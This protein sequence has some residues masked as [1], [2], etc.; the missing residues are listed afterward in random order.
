MSSRSADCPPSLL[1]CTFMAM[2]HQVCIIT[3][4]RDP[5]GPFFIIVEMKHKLSEGVFQDRTYV[6]EL[7]LAFLAID[8]TPSRAA[9]RLTWKCGWT[10]RRDAPRL[11]R[12]CRG[13][14][15][16]VRTEAETK[17]NVTDYSEYSAF[18][19]YSPK[20][21]QA[22]L[23]SAYLCCAKFSERIA[24]VED[25]ERNSYSVGAVIRPSYDAFIRNEHTTG[26]VVG[27][28]GQHV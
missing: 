10:L 9:S 3:R 27:G 7:L 16:F 17:G 23:R 8:S 21:W 18:R 4:L 25:I 13:A 20:A 15:G 19:E 24:S 11:C 2:T 6:E 12:G 1:R 5:F 28:D 22:A 26:R 14:L